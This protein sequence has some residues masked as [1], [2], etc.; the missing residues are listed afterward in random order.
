MIDSDEVSLSLTETPRPTTYPHEFS[1]FAHDPASVTARVAA[2]YGVDPLTVTH[3]RWHMKKQVNQLQDTDGK[4]SLTSS[5][6]GGF[7]EL[8]HLFQTGITPYYLGLMKPNPQDSCPIRIQ[9]LPRIEELHD[10]LGLADPLDEVP[11]SPVKEVVQVYPDR[12]AFCVAQ[13]C[14][15]YCRY[16]FRKR[17]DEED[18][19]HFNRKIVDQGIR[20]IAANPAI[21]DVLVTGGDPFVANDEAIL[22]VTERLR[23]IPHVEIIRF[24]TRTPVT[25]PYRVTAELAKKLAAFH[26]IFINTHFNCAEEVT[27]EAAQAIENLVNNGFPVGNQAVLLRGVNDSTEKMIQLSRALLKIRVRPYYLFHPHLVEGTEHLRVPVSKGMEIMRTMRGKITG[28]GIPTYIMDTPAGKVPLTPQQIL[29]EDGED[30]LIEDRY[31]RIW[32]E[33][34]ALAPESSK[35][36][37]PLLKGDQS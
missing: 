20:Y 21:R 4:I 8:Q 27:P 10:S 31:G 16:C 30:L 17:R 15:V 26:P 37:E 2:L 36:P 22:S 3:W 1:R 7:E 13:L 34:G 33:K 6:K 12:V 11:H 32:R 18:G 14:P 23:Q 5:E 25:L 28:L 35:A 29:G 19:L 9:A 24:G